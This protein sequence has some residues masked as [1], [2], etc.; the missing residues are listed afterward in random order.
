MYDNIINYF[1]D[2]ITSFISIGVNSIYINYA[3]ATKAAYKHGKTKT[4][5]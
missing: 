3:M 1:M 4:L 5:I 2:K